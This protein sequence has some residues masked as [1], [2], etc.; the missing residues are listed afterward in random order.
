MQIFDLNAFL[1]KTPLQT[2]ISIVFWVG[3]LGMAWTSTSL[4]FGFLFAFAA[5]TDMASFAFEALMYSRPERGVWDAVWGGY[6]E[7]NRS[8]KLGYLFAGECCVLDF[9]FDG[10][11]R[12]R[13]RPAQ[14]ADE[15]GV[16]I[17]LR[18]QVSCL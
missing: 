13:L 15:Y 11:P 7:D 4:F 17:E 6:L 8:G 10:T 5:L 9:I 16:E 1:R 3:M 18:Q 2:A 14:L 12:C